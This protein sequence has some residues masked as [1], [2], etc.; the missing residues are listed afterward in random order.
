MRSATSP[1]CLNLGNFITEVSIVNC[2]CNSNRVGA[3]HYFFEIRGLFFDFFL[4]S[5]H[6]IGL[7]EDKLPLLLLPLTSKIDFNYQ[8]PHLRKNLLIDSV[9]AMWVNFYKEYQS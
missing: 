4:R 1:L 2:C 5:V 9:F 8:I 7:K 3:I 6:F